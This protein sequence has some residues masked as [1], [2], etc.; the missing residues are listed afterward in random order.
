MDSTLSRQ[1]GMSVWKSF[2]GA[3]YSVCDSPDGQRRFAVSSA[4]KI[5]ACALV[6]LEEADTFSDVRAFSKSKT[7]ASLFLK[8]P[9]GT[10][11]CRR[12]RQLRL[13]DCEVPRGDCC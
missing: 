6:P 10:A 4:D 12:L 13:K 11:V 2:L 7:S 5:I 9:D 3:A 1:L 8:R